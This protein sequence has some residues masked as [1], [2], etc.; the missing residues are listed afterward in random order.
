MTDF[1]SSTRKVDCPD[2][3][4]F[5][6]KKPE[7]A[8]AIHFPDWELRIKNLLK[9]YSSLSF[10]NDAAAAKKTQSIVKELTD[11]YAALQAHYMAA[12]LGWCGNPCSIEAEKR[13]IEEKAAIRSKEYALRELEKDSGPSGNN[14]GRIMLRKL[15]NS[16]E[17]NKKKP[18]AVKTYP[19]DAEQK[20]E[21]I[22]EE[23]ELALEE[24]L[25]YSAEGISIPIERLDKILKTVACLKE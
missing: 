12:Y 16:R 3:P 21:Q 22:S 8:F 2:G 14:H 23:Q 1:R 24:K 19:Y 9:I 7:R 10:E 5:I 17:K 20:R 11:N 25:S 15:P 6:L 13:F 18:R 4:R